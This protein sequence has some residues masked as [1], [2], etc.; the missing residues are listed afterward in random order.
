M[1]EKIYMVDKE[2]RN[3]S[4]Y[5][6]KSKNPEILSQVIEEIRVKGDGSQFQGLM[7]LL[8]KT[9]NQDI[10]GQILKLFSD[11]KSTETIPLMMD[12]IRDKKYSAQLK[13]LLTC[14]WQNGLNYSPWLPFFIDLV[15]SEEFPVSFE[16]F[17]VI[18]NMYGK[19]DDSIISGQLVKIDDSLKNA[20]EQKRYLLDE[21]KHIIQNLPERMW[22]P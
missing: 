5:S 15:I 18:E 7:E 20:D 13:D 11:L 19:I 17:T 22:N 21:L 9:E 6:L 3:K 16:A 12:A 4:L 8:H 10:K 1:Q 14:C 2:Q